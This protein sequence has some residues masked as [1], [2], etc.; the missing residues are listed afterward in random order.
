MMLL[1]VIVRTDGRRSSRGTDR[2]QWLLIHKR[3]EH[4]DASWDVDDHPRSVKTG[5]L[6]IES[7]F[8]AETLAQL[9]AAGHEVVI[10]TRQS[11]PVPPRGAPP[12]S[13]RWSRDRADGR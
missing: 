11:A 3:D 13:R 1:F 8:S 2:E 10:L 7:R 12:A 6:A 9:A 4:A 5:K